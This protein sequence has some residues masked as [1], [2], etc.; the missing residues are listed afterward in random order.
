MNCQE[1]KE[2]LGAYALGSLT[3]EE[4]LHANEHLKTC[5]QCK[6][7]YQE[8]Q[9]VV[10]LLPL[11]A[12][13]ASPSSR[14][15]ERI[16]ASVQSENRFLYQKQQPLSAKLKRSYRHLRLL[17]IAAM[18]IISLSGGLSGMVIWNIAL[19]QQLTQSQRASRIPNVTHSPIIYSLS[20]S[21]TAEGQ[22]AKGELVYFPVEHKITLIIHGLPKL[23]DMH[24][25]QGWMINHNHLKSIGLLTVYSEV[26]ILNFTGDIQGWETAAVSL[27]NSPQ[28]SQDAPQGP[29][30][31][32]STLKNSL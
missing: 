23:K 3:P 30:V 19:Q 27:E 2:V 28:G 18:L 20:N 16:L 21:T 7:P 32:A 14:V 26:A 15:K 31:L 5:I 10:Q 17:A 9:S 8:I 4:E 22:N 12:P 13:A 29:V 25:Y 6:K 11:S 24:V 1:F